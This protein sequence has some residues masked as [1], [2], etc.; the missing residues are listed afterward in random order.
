MTL[1]QKV[2]KWFVG[3]VFLIGA[4]LAGVASFV[5]YLGILLLPY[6]LAALAVLWIAHSC[7]GWG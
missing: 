2:Q 6:I 3:G 1:T 7:F 5:I 4:V